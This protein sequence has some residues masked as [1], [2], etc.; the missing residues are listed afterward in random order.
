M[1]AIT[2]LLLFYVAIPIDGYAGLIEVGDFDVGYVVRLE[3]VQPNSGGTAIDFIDGNNGGILLHVKP[4]ID[5]NVSLYIC[6][7]II[8]KALFA[9]NL[10]IH[11]IDYSECETF[12]GEP[13]LLAA[14][15]SSTRQSVSQL[16]R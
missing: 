10:Y 1:W 7:F 9:D 11:Y 6:S 14:V 8:L 12:G 4:H 13:E 5:L 3:Y 16:Q 15:H 2:A